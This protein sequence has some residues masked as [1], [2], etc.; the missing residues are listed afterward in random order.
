MVAEL[1][2]ERD[3][4]AA[5]RKIFQALSDETRYKIVQLLAK[6]PLT[7]DDIS[8]ETGRARSTVESHL[9]I[10]IAA[11]LVAKDKSTKPYLYRATPLA[12]ELVEGGLDKLD[13]RLAS[14]VKVEL[15]RRAWIPLP[16]AA[17]AGLT[18]YIALGLLLYF[19]EKPI[20]LTPVAIILLYDFLKVHPKTTAKLLLVFAFLLS[21]L[22]S[23]MESKPALFAIVLM[24]AQWIV[25]LSLLA[26]YEV[27]VKRLLRRW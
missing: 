8:K 17:L 26:L 6:A 1:L 7:A 13:E 10:L 2:P 16:H 12:K 15:P 25:G 9:S 23:L 4:H 27:L 18:L 5:K 20:F 3:S 19:V 22:I 21:I 14:K 11:G 24:V